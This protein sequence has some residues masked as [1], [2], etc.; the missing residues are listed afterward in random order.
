MLDVP[1]RPRA[2]ATPGHTFGHMALHVADREL[3]FAGDA[4]VTKDPYSERRGPRLVARAATA[5][6]GQA[7]R[8]LAAIEATG[9]RILAPGHG[10]V[11]DRGA[12][13]AV[14]HARRAGA[15]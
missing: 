3:L 5:D 14:A 2:V 15:A 11:W 6:S 10:D 4:L 13:E 1:G 7:L 9:A 12:A 8:S